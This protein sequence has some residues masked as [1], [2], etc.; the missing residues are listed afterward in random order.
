M[1]L[2]VVDNRYLGEGFAFII[3]DLPYSDRWKY[4][5][6]RE[7]FTEKEED[8]DARMLVNKLNTEFDRIVSE[9]R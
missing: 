2:S 8:T 6:H 3:R 7:Y 5:I 1:R 4:K 9:G